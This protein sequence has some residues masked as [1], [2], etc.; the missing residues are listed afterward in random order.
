METF[1]GSR[2]CSWIGATSG[3]GATAAYR[4]RHWCM[5]NMTG[6]EESMTGCRITSGDKASLEAGTARCRLQPSVDKLK[7]ELYMNGGTRGYC[8]M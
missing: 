4:Q 3:G 6:D 5:K 2:D 1:L 8:H 7:G